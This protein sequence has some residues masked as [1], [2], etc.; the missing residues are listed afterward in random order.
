MVSDYVENFVEPFFRVGYIHTT[1]LIFVFCANLHQKKSQLKFPHQSHQFPKKSPAFNPA[2]HPK[3]C[4]KP[5]PFPTDQ[6]TFLRFRGA[7]GAWVFL[8]ES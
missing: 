7:I 6:P 8:Y 3:K 4:P 5:T 2:N 1:N